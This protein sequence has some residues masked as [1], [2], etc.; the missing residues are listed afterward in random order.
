VAQIRHSCD[1]GEKQRLNVRSGNRKTAAVKGDVLS[2][3]L[4]HLRC[5]LFRLLDNAA[6]TD[7]DSG[8]ADR[9]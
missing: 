3:D 7:V 1:F 2:G 5:N 6:G 4:H 8:S 9:H